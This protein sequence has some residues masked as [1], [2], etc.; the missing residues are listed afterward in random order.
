[1]VQES[2]NKIELMVA[3]LGGQGLLTM[4]WLL[5]EAALLRYKHVVY[6]PNYG[7]M[8]RGGE[9]ECTI[10]VSENEISS[11]AIYTLMSAIVMGSEAFQQLES[12]VK[13]GGTILIDSSLLSE[14]IS[15]ND[16]G[17]FYIPASQLAIDLG[18]RQAANLIMLGAY[19]EITKALP[20][21]LVVGA[22]EKKMSDKRKQRLLSINKEALRKGA[23]FA[24]NYKGD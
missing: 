17:V 1:M 7:P 2:S 24:A 5:A 18:G 4:G 16:L 11:P 23:E 8:M 12:R 19:L 9:S 15:R 22:L 20:S 21:E 13:P 6:F 10:I 14:K 3:G